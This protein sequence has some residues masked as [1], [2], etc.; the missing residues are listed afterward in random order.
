MVIPSGASV[1]LPF[2]RIHNNPDIY[3]NPEQWNPANFDADKVA[4]RPSNSF[5]PFGAGPHICIGKSYIRFRV[6]PTCWSFISIEN[7]IRIGK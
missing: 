7:R 4:G 5:M 2:N 3:P 1:T 6:N